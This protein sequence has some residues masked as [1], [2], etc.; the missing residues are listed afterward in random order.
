MR[1]EPDA[2]QHG[3]FIIDQSQDPRKRSCCGPWLPTCA[4][5]TFLMSMSRQ[6]AF[7][8]NELDFSQGWPIGPFPACDKYREAMLYDDWSD[9]TASERSRLIG[10]GMHLLQ[11]SLAWQYVLG[12]LVLRDDC[13][14]FNPMEVALAMSAAKAATQSHE[15]PADRS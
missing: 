9:Y 6:H 1:K 5:S 12:N 2:A 4:K 10:N 15:P 11:M 13:Q 8:P 14:R 7:T 3:A